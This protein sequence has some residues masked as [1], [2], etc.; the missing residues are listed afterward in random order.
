MPDGEGSHRPG[1]AA[2]GGSETPGG[3][4]PGEH[5]CCVSLNA[6][7]AIGSSK[8]SL[9][10]G[11]GGPVAR[12]RLPC[13]AAIAGDKQRQATAHRVAKHQ[14]LVFIPPRHR[15]QEDSSAGVVVHPFGMQAVGLRACNP[16]W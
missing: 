14:A 2:V 7:V 10:F 9:A 15:I 5:P 6:D 8:S 16:R 13:L 1:M 4:S 11:R 3:A 12:R